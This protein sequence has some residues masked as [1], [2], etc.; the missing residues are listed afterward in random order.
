MQFKFRKQEFT[1]QP[2]TGMRYSTRQLRPSYAVL[3]PL[4]HPTAKYNSHSHAAA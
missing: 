1:Y 2:Q 3:I 4:Q